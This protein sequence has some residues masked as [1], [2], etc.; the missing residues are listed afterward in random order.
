MDH[1]F[2]LHPEIRPANYVTS[3]SPRE[4]SLEAKVAELKQKLKSFAFFTQI[5]EPHVGGGTS[6]S[7]TYM[8]GASGEVVA[9][10][11]TRSQTL[12]DAVASTSGSSNEVL[13]PR[14]A[15]LA[16]QVG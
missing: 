8:F 13:H 4:Q 7:D 2:Q 5:S 10:A 15:G 16:D 9:A 1:C 3:K 12:A 6:G 11:S 14:H